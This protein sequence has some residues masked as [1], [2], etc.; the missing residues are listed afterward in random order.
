MADLER[1]PCACDGRNEN[2]RRLLRQVTEIG[3]EQTASAKLGNSGAEERAANVAQRSSLYPDD[4]L[5]RFDERRHEGSYGRPPWIFTAMARNMIE[6]VSVAIPRLV[7]PRLVLRAFRREDFPT[8][9]A[10]SADPE[11][12]AF[13]GGAV[14]QRQ[15][16]RMFVV[17]IGGWMLDNGGWLALTLPEEDR[18]IGTV[19]AFRRENA[20]DVVEI[21][22]SVFKDHWRKGY[23]RE[24]AQAMV[25]FA[26]DEWKEKR[27]IAYV[28]AAN[29]G[30]VGVAKGVGMTREGE[31]EFYGQPID[32]YAITRG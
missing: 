23:A 16:W 15:A 22:W 12:M 27:L 14:D 17:G 13:I 6:H 11:A 3:I 5:V 29:A 9:A 31:A 19:G 1:E 20:P 32:L 10:N 25:D 7:T 2:V 18:M 26:F 21:G 4:D 28:D 8:Y 30:S 24:A